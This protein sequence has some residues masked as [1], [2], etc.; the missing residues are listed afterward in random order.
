MKKPVLLYLLLALI[1]IVSV[2]NSQNIDSLLRSAESSPDDTNKVHILN[3][4]SELYCKN[5]D[6]QRAGNY[7]QEAL[8][9]SNRLYFKA[10]KAAALKNIGISA[11]HKLQVASD[12]KEELGQLEQQIK[13]AVAQKEIEK[14]T[15]IKNISIIGL[16]VVLLFSALLYN[17][18]RLIKKQKH[19]IE[20]EKKRSD[21]LLLNILPFDVAEELKTKGATT[22]K[23]FDEVTVMFTDFKGFTQ[24]SEKLTPEELV[25]EI[26][27][28]FKAFDE[29][30]TKHNIEKIKTMGDSYMCVGGLPRPNANHSLNVVR[31]AIEI[32]QFMTNHN[33]A[34]IK[35]GTVVFEMRIG[36]HSGSVVAG[37]VGAKKFAYDIWGDTVNIASRMES[38][39]EEGKINISGA[40]YE[41]VKNHVTCIPRGKVHAKNKG[42][43]D[44]YF[45]ESVV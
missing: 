27:T 6:Y 21:E 14:Q 9:L 24:I 5:T 41:L 26:D 22:A 18:F 40:T 28:C 43:I 25:A 8:I 1:A 15:L 23:K 44:M 32:Q 37:I 38:S 29:I 33:N 45:V 4:L 20:A 35:A 13:E 30:I 19:I 10:G 7:A 3:Q 17:R 12:K 42:E 36:I 11:M 31:A 39:G 16:V 34:R 2:S